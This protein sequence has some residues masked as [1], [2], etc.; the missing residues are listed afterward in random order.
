ML[1][2]RDDLEE[3]GYSRGSLMIVSDVGS[4]SGHSSVRDVGELPGKET[5]GS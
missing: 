1:S 3:S 2:K 4:V 5:V